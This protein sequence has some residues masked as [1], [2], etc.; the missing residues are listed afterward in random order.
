[1]K[2]S[3]D[4]LLFAVALVTTDPAIA[5]GSVVDKVRNHGAPDCA[6]SEDPAVEVYR[7]DA[8]TYILRQSKCVHFEAPFIYVLF[9]EHTALVLDTGATADATRFPLYETV[10]GLVAQRQQQK[11][12]LLVAHSHSHEDH[13]EGDAQFQDKPG[14]TVV[15]PNAKAVRAHFG[16]WSWPEGSA[17]VDL[18]RSH[19]G[20]RSGARASGRSDRGA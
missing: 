16:F 19:A 4:A 17:N 13:R 8:D 18:G 20:R 9:G 15:A 6:R 14:V 2:A 12:G 3:H 10:R 7:H 5:S 1:M 11:I